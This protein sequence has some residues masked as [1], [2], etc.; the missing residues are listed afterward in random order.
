MAMVFKLTNKG[1]FSPP[2]RA[3]ARKSHKHGCSQEFFGA[4]IEDVQCK[5]AGV[6]VNRRMWTVGRCIGEDGVASKIQL[7]DEISYERQYR[8]RAGG[9]GAGA[10]S[11]RA[12]ATHMVAHSPTASIPPRRCTRNDGDDGE[13]GIQCRRVQGDPALTLALT[14]TGGYGHEGKGKGGGGAHHGRCS[15]AR[16]CSVAAASGVHA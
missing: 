13:V 2:A 11:A 9:A 16:S 10:V 6:H 1:T 7:A 4:V 8:G 15:V 5:A 3:L 14:W 12:L